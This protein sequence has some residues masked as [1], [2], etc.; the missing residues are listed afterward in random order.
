M[1]RIKNELLNKVKASLN[2]TA[3]NCY[4]NAVIYDCQTCDATCYA[5]CVDSC[6]SE[7]R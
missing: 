5:C 7:N 6:T 2:S 4:A 1:F 3:L